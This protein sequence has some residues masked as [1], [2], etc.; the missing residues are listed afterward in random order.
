MFKNIVLFSLLILI[1]ICL[2]ILIF[3]ISKLIKYLKDKNGKK[4]LP[5]IL[6]TLGISTMAVG[7]VGGFDKVLLIIALLLKRTDLDK[8]ANFNP[9]IFFSGIIILIIGI[10]T[11]YF[12]T[13]YMCILN[14]NAYSKLNLDKDNSIFKGKKVEEKEIDIVDIYLNRFKPDYNSEY[15]KD[16][17]RIVKNDVLA[18]KFESK[19]RKCGYTGIAPV[20]IVMYAGSFLDRIKIDEY[21]EFDNKCTKEHYLL[22]DNSEKY[23]KLKLFSDLNSISKNFEEVVLAISITNSIEDNQLIQFGNIPKIHLKIDKVGDN[24]IKSKKQLIEYVNLIIEYAEKIS[25]LFPNLKRINLVCSAQSCL[26]LEIGRMCPEGTRISE[27]VCYQFEIKDTIKYP[28]G[29]VIN[30][31]NSGDFINRKEVSKCT[32]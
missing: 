17:L 1:L 4:N 15:M 13:D 24:A 20:P 10:V 25:R 28:W 16:I 3:K 8:I 21:I 11:Y 27:I 26:A 6:I 5:E 7:Y 2:I 23:Q 29:I 31:D 12:R 32:I 22:N 14:I 19:G 30:G 9:I 18:F